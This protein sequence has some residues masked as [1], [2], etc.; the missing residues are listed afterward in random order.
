[1]HIKD[2]VVLFHVWLEKPSL[3][4]QSYIQKIDNF[5]VDSNKVQGEAIFPENFVKFLSGFLCT[6]VGL[7]G[8]C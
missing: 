4:I 5:L 2:L 7:G 3:Q 6:S 8:Y 1:M